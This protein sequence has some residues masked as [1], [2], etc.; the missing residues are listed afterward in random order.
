MAPVG[1]YCPG[2]GGFNGNIWRVC[3]LCFAE[4]PGYNVY[5]TKLN[6]NRHDGVIV[7][8]NEQFGGFAEEIIS[9][10][11][12]GL[13]I[14]FTVNG[15]SFEVL[16]LYKSPGD[17]QMSFLDDLDTILNEKKTTK[18]CIIVGDLNI[19][20]LGTDMAMRSYDDFLV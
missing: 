15:E 20:Y 10:N 8:L 18:N 17:C 16:T 9:D 13:K 6:K 3:Q 19:D 4:L 5:Y 7:Y 14:R 2:Y 12:T 1:R 11:I